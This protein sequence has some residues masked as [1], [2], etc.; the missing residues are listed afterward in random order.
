[1][2]LQRSSMIEEM[3]TSAASA[4]VI[5]MGRARAAR[6]ARAERRAALRGCCS[7]WNGG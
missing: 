6:I 1:M 2:R 7:A 3:Q 5:G 4:A